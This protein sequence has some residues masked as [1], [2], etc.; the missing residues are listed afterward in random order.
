MKID[1]FAISDIHATN[2]FPYRKKSFGINDGL[3]DITRIFT[4]I[5]TAALF[6]KQN[7]NKTILVIMGDIFDNYHYDPKSLECIFNSIKMVSPTFD[8]IYIMV[9]NH[10]KLND[11]ENN[12]NILK[13][14]VDDFG[15]K[16]NILS[17]I[18]CVRYNGVGMIFVPF[19]KGDFREQE[20]IIKKK[21]KI[22]SKTKSKILFVHNDIKGA[23]FDNSIIAEEGFSARRFSPN[24][25]IGKGFDYVLCGHLHG[26]QF[27]KGK[28]G[29]YEKTHI[30]IGS[31]FQQSFAE[32]KQHNKG[33]YILKTY[34]KEIKFVN[35]NKTNFHIFE[36][37]VKNA[38][39][40]LKYKIKHKLDILK[41]SIVRIKLQC[42][43]ED[44]I[45]ITR[46][47]SKIRIFFKE[48]DLNYLVFSIEIIKKKN[49]I[50]N[51][52]KI[53]NNKSRISK[54]NEHNAGK[55]NNIKRLNVKMNRVYDAEKN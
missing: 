24:G 32:S 20:K 2:N 14:A 18:S 29:V 49:R 47:K 3:L 22:I 6:S 1:V 37:S 31:P 34:N 36:L 41:K 50:L 33:Y 10:D 7:K 38:L 46:V 23:K 53:S 4:N 48:Y 27:L 16:I 52:D 44:V 21:Y 8:L 26:K 51:L 39:K 54:Y 25:S 45:L 15:D 43:K 42:I 11:K 55:K 9:G 40:D 30:I 5:T 28:R 19:I 17:E 35:C 12:L 13:S